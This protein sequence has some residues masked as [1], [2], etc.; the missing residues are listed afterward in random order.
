[1]TWAIVVARLVAFGL[2]FLVGAKCASW[3][4]NREY[5]DLLRK[6]GELGAA[7]EKE[8]SK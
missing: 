8:E 1:V 4:C 7:A 3:H 2:G 6:I 5:A